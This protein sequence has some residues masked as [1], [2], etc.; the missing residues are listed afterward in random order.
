MTGSTMG[1]LL[2]AALWGTLAGCASERRHHERVYAPPPP[3]PRVYVQDDYVYYPAYEVYYSRSQRH[4]IYRDGSSWVSRPAPPRV[5]VEVL[6]ASPSVPLN[7]H[8]APSRHHATVVRQYPKQ[9]APPG[10]KPNH[11]QPY[12]P[13]SRR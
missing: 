11:G 5:A 10:P 1:F 2:G 3:P 13:E 6:V 4:Y 8:D 12:I 7:F 9:W